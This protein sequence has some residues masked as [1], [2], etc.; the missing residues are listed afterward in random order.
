M[1]NVIIGY[2]GLITLISYI[3]IHAMKDVIE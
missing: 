3:M 2:V 1:I